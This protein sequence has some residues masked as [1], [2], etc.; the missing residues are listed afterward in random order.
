MRVTNRTQRKLQSQSQKEHSKCTYLLRPHLDSSV[1]RVF[2]KEVIVE[3]DTPLL[4][5][6]YHLFIMSTTF[7]FSTLIFDSSFPSV[8]NTTC[9]FC[10]INCTLQIQTKQPNLF[11]FLIVIEFVRI[12]KLQNRHIMDWIELVIHTKIFN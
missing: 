9:I 12:H 6:K 1:E 2:A 8:V 3:G 4:P 10:A 5:P 11:G 7:A